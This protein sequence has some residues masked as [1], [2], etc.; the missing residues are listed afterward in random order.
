MEILARPFLCCLAVQMH[1]GFTT[2]DSFP[3][4]DCCSLLVLDLTDSHLNEIVHFYNSPYAAQ[5]GF[6]RV[7]VSIRADHHLD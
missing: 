4:I 6:T 5:D 7:R 2:P 1:N 3:E